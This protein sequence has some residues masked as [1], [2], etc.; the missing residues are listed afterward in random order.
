[1]LTA[2]YDRLKSNYREIFLETANEIRAV[3]ESVRPKGFVGDIF[4]NSSVVWSSIG[5]VQ[6]IEGIFIV[7]KA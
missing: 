4:N 2:E 6:F 5:Y 1:M 3:V 7:A